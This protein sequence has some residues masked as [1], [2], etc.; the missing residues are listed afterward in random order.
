MPEVVQRSRIV[1]AAGQEAGDV[2]FTTG[3]TGSSSR[4]T[5]V[6]GILERLIDAE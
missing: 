1:I 6:P 3:W 5:F 4:R 2:V